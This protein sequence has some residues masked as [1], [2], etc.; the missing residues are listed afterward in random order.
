MTTSDAKGIHTAV[1]EHYARAARDADVVLR[2]DGHR[3]EPHWP[4]AL[5]GG[6]RPRSARNCVGRSAW[7]RQPHACWPI[8]RPGEYVLDLGSGG[9]IDVLLSAR[10]VGPDRAWPTGST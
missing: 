5:L 6:G 2:P 3:D 4:I 7:L 1:R 8:C 9:G 10:R